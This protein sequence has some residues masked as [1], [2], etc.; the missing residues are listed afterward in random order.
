[1]AAVPVKTSDHKFTTSLKVP[2]K[3]KAPEAAKRD[4]I[5][6]AGKHG[7]VPVT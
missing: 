5:L 7:F 3:G 1:M 4:L 2:A 6:G